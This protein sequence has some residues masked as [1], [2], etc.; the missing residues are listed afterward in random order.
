[1]KFTTILS[2]PI[3]A[4]TGSASA[5]K[6][7]ADAPDGL[8][9]GL[10]DNNGNETHYSGAQLTSALVKDLLVSSDFSPNSTDSAIPTAVPGKRDTGKANCA[11]F[12]VD[13]VDL[14]IGSWAFS[15]WFGCGQSMKDTGKH[16]SATFKQGGVVFYACDYGRNGQSYTRD[17]LLDDYN[18]IAATCGKR[19][20]WV[21]HAEWKSSYGYTQPGVSFC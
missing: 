17:Q 2:I 12:E 1:M 3:I 11:E 4:L 9:L 13:G 7:P 6:I 15:D 18:L 21:S 5:L 20:G 14:K 19:A 10:V 16:I 8:S